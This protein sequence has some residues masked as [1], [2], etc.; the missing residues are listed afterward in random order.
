MAEW[1]SV[2]VTWNV[3]SWSGGHEC[4]PWSGR[5]R[6]AQYFCR[7]WTINT[8]TVPMRPAHQG[9]WD[10]FNQIEII[11]QTPVLM[12]CMPSEWSACS[13]SPPAKQS[14]IKHGQIHYQLCHWNSNLAGFE[15]RPG[16]I[17]HLRVSGN[18]LHL[19]DKKVRL[20]ATIWKKIAANY[21]NKYWVT[22]VILKGNHPE[23]DMFM[24]L[25]LHLANW[26]E[27]LLNA[28]FW[29]WIK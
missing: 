28:T 11:T 9:L 10:S 14:Q 20:Q 13:L 27:T 18:F 2:S 16:L 5:T 25:L 4:E 24:Q 29:K 19:A 1:L 6:G 23:K 22:V 15:S 21:K 12:C 3:L 7:T 8:Y 17:Q 26:N